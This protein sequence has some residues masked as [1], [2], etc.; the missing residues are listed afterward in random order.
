LAVQAMQGLKTKL[1]VFVSEKPSS[2]YSVL[3]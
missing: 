3:S 2:F 1:A